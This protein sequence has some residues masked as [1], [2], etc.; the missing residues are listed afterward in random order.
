MAKRTRRGRPVSFVTTAGTLSSG[1]VLTDTNGAASS[2][3][4]DKRA[5][6]TVTA[7]VGAAG[8]HPPRAPAPARRRVRSGQGVRHGHR[9]YLGR[10]VNRGHRAGR[11]APTQGV[12]GLPSRSP[13]R[14]QPPTAAPCATSTVNWGDGN[15]PEPG[16]VHRRQIPRRTRSRVMAATLVTAN[17]CRC[18]PATATRRPRR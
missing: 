13:S 6:R 4:D 5:G 17:R 18:G 12:A 16:L 2:V 10:A 14:L 11:R 3:L 8:D 15:R 1:L 7:S 9:E